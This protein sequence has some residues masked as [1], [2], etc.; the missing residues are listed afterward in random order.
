MCWSKN[1]S[2]G[3]TII[4]AI[5]SYHSYNSIDKLWGLFVF[6]STLMQIIHYVGYL[7][8]NDCKHP[9]NK[10]MAYLNYFHVAFQPTFFILGFSSLFRK[11]KVINQKEYDILM[12]FVYF[13]IIIGLLLIS[14]IIP[15]NINKYY[16][17]KLEKEGCVWCGKTCSFSG[18]KHISFNIPLRNRP[19]YFTPSMFIHFALF[20]IPFILLFKRNVSLLMFGI[21]ITSFIPSVL[22]KITP[23][24]A[25]TIWCSNSIIQ[26]LISFYLLTNKLI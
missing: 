14:R 21:F 18:T 15:I 26:I 17:Y 2:L 4:G 16:T 20:Y 12:N 1:V 7:F 11:Y 13:S 8:I 6:Y 5:F 25:A 22:F 19:I 24:E 23:A 9:V 3:M 10:M